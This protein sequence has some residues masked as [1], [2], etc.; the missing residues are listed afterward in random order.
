MAET[1]QGCTKEF[2]CVETECESYNNGKNCQ[3]CD[4]Y[5]KCNFCITQDGGENPVNNPDVCRD[6]AYN[7][8]YGYP[9][10]ER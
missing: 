9:E 8:C 3:T 2:W 6:R 5:G 1:I 4:K 7:I 10:E